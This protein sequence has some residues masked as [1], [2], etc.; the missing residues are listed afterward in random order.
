MKVNNAWCY[1][2]IFMSVYAVCDTYLYTK[3][4]NTFFWQYKTE[5]E[6]QLQQKII[7]NVNCKE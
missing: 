5:A 7:N 6:L 2:W 1:F 3:G 4:N